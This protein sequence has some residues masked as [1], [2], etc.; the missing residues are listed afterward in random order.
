MREQ[1]GNM[2]CGKVI[3]ARFVRLTWRM[4][5]V[6]E[7]QQ[8]VGYSRIFSRKH[9]TLAAAI[10]LPCQAQGNSGRERAEFFGNAADAVAIMVGVPSRRTRRAL[11]TIGQVT[12]KR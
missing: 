8:R 9:R 4:Q 10:R 2:Q 1:C 3:R 12:A 6:R 5:R 7:Q 11:L